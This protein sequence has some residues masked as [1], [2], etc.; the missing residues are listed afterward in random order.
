MARPLKKINVTTMFPIGLEDPAMH[1]VKGSG[2]NMFIKIGNP[3]TGP[4][5]TFKVIKTETDR[6]T[7]RNFHAFC[8]FDN[9]RDLQRAESEIM[10]KYHI[11]CHRTE[12]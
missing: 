2:N 6:G 4:V 8:S 3:L 12:E 1:D 11:G 7:V 10:Q 5:Y 9:A